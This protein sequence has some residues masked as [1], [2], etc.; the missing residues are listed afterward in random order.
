MI[1]ISTYLINSN[2]KEE[3]MLNSNQTEVVSTRVVTEDDLRQQKYRGCSPSDFEFNL[4]G[5]ELLEKNRFKIFVEQLSMQFDTN[6]TDFNED[7]SLE[8]WRAIELA[9]SHYEDSK[10]NEVIKN[11]TDKR[12]DWSKVK[13]GTLLEDKSD[14]TIKA[15]FISF[16][17]KTTVVSYKRDGYVYQQ[18]V[19]YCNLKETPIPVE[20]PATPEIRALEENKNSNL[21]DWSKVKRGTLINIVWCKPFEAVFINFDELTTSVEYSKDGHTK[22]LDKM[23]CEL[24][25]PTVTPEPKVNKEI[26]WSEVKE[27]DIIFRHRNNYKTPVIFQS[28][29]AITN[30]VFFCYTNNG[31]INYSDKKYFSG[32]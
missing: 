6:F 30:A 11:K 14:N 19:N 17:K 9:Q 29:R 3:S 20:T 31:V 21:T 16:D 32:L 10:H 8:L 22:F 5:T 18:F 1:T 25:E 2:T 15:E 23:Y 4:K 12:I 27:G 24:K 26:N 28:F 7:E 13:V